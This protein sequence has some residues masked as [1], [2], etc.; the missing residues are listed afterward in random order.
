MEP[1]VLIN[2][3]EVGE[4]HEE[5]FLARW[6]EGAAYMRQQEGFIST[7]LHESFDPKARFRFINVARWR[8]PADFQRAVSTPEFQALVRQTP[9]PHYPAVYQVAAE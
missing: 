5:E 6:Q 9:F 8:S 7:K 4:G 3:F 1:V 2:P